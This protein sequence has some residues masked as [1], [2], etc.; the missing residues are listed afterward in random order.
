VPSGLK[1]N[2]IKA[3]KQQGFDFYAKSENISHEANLV[4]GKTSIDLHWD[5]MRPGRT[6][7]PMTDTLLSTR[8]DH[9]SHWGMSNEANLFVML[10]HPVFTK[11]ATAPQAS[12]MRTVDLAQVMAGK[13]WEV[14]K[15]IQLLETA[16]LKTAA[17]ITL[18]WFR[19]L[20]HSTI[21]NEAIEKLKPGKLRQKYLNW[22][23]EKNLAS[24][25]Q[26]KP[27]YVQLGFTLPAHDTPTDAIQAVKKQRLAGRNAQKDLKRI[28]GEIK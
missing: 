10:V 23:L 13:D 14:V 5:I 19:Q 18:Q 7:I 11:Y 26:G 27:I 1:I 4:K 17:W 24:R 28:E 16:G 20:T 12:L 22:W 3:F 15:V 6:R 21:A 9:G 8:Q 25:L 2:A